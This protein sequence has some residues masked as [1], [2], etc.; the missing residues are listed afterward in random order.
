MTAKK[1]NAN[2]R[3]QLDLG[4]LLADMG[5]NL[6]LDTLDTSVRATKSKQ[7]SNVNEEN[8][9]STSLTNIMERLNSA[10]GAEQN[11]SDIPDQEENDSACQVNDKSNVANE[12]PEDINTD[13]EKKEKEV[14]ENV[15]DEKI[16]QAKTETAAKEQK[17]IDKKEQ[18]TETQAIIY[19]ADNLK[20][21]SNDQQIEQQTESKIADT[22]TV[23]KTG[24]D[25][26]S[27][28]EL[29]NQEESRGEEMEDSTRTEK[30]N[31]PE[32]INQENEFMGGFIL[33]TS[34]EEEDKCDDDDFFRGVTYTDE[35][36]EPEF[37]DDYDINAAGFD[38][39]EDYQEPSQIPDEHV[40]SDTKGH[41]E[42]SSASTATQ[43][44]AEEIKV[45]E[46]IT[47][48]ELFTANSV[49]DKNFGELKTAYGPSLSEND[50]LVLAATC[51]SDIAGTNPL[52]VEYAYDDELDMYGILV[53]IYDSNKYWFIT[54]GSETF[55]ETLWHLFTRD[56]LKI[57]ANYPAVLNYIN[58]FGIKPTNLISLTALYAASHTD[59]SRILLNKIVKPAE[60]EEHTIKRFMS[61]Y[62][63][64]YT[65][66]YSE[67][68]VNSD[69][70]RKCMYCDNLMAY[71]FD[72]SDLVDVRGQNMTT[73]NY[74]DFV[75]TYSDDMEKVGKDIIITYAT[76]PN[77]LFGINPEEMYWNVIKRM[78][79]NHMFIRFSIRILSIKDNEL[80]ISC[81]QHLTKNISDA[82]I[83]YIKKSAKKLNKQAIPQ[84]NIA[85]K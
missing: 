6:N 79:D 34:N 80:I 49:K 55:K 69:A 5:A 28:A 17:D 44:P 14:T 74:K 3:G 26:E 59:I 48:Q 51:E 10:A 2:V 73:T 41:A 58:N 12:K 63:E 38:Y 85:Y 24:E 53:Y 76:N 66:W 72:I 67:D 15:D 60:T 32:E 37:T 33:P 56:R 27:K 20:K 64:S 13:K 22:N 65:Q 52:S 46:N 35:D 36:V 78:Y 9:E 61:R 18:K 31:N 25:N 75:F 47:P 68:I 70:F 39:P 4:A 23:V 50:K 57:T 16:E 42:D 82:V 30:Q 71:S 29:L 54:E 8:T 40:E 11:K 77:S 21:E 1:K 62:I 7:V 84:I 83:D 81:P 45:I 19:E 43:A